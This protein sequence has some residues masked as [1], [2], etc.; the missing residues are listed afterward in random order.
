MGTVLTEG[1]VV[2]ATAPGQIKF[3]GIEFG[4]KRFARFE[5]CSSRRADLAAL[6]RQLRLDPGADPRPDVDPA[7]RAFLAAYGPTRDLSLYRDLTAD[8]D[9][10]TRDATRFDR[11]TPF[12]KALLRDEVA[13]LR[14]E[15]D[16][17]GGWRLPL[18]LQL[19][20]QSDVEGTLARL[21]PSWRTH[22][23]TLTAPELTGTRDVSPIDHSDFRTVAGV[24]LHHHPGAP[25]GPYFLPWTATDARYYRAAGLVAYGVSPFALVASEAAAIG[26]P[27]ERMQ[28]PAFSDGV[29]LY[30][31]LV[32]A[33][34]D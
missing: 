14:L 2:E 30:R 16:P 32:R 18:S 3:W 10:L 9:R 31:D 6:A 13:P 29:A 24:I 21:L 15:P 27:N 17:G 11:L 26:K 7:I 28:L 19:L 5:A 22:G 33:L 20:P 12:L 25:V 8:L 23:L 1:G 4:Q 34:V